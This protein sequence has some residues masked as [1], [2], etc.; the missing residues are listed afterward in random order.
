[1]GGVR[2]KDIYYFTFRQ[3]DKICFTF[4]SEI[5]YHASYIENKSYID[6]EIDIDNEIK[7]NGKN[8]GFVRI[9]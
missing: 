7:Y 8:C 5:S 3:S 1:M 9:Y 6:K 4:I 2:S